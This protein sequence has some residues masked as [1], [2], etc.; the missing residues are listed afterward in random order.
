MNSSI[1]RSKNLVPAGIH[2][3]LWGIFIGHKNPRLDKL[4]THCAVLKVCTIYLIINI[5]NIHDL[6]SYL[7]T[8]TMFFLSTP[9]IQTPR[10]DELT[11]VFPVGSF[12]RGFT[13]VSYKSRP[14][15]Q[16]FF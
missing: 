5:M 4:R 10:L 16:K 3:F 12:E 1:R 15:F 14:F 2:A 9:L 7:L 6:S 8:K 11:Y 13:V